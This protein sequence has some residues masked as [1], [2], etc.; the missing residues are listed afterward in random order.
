MQKQ[1][2]AKAKRL[3]V[4][5]VA[6]IINPATGELVGAQY[7]WNTGER[8]LEWFGEKHTD[9]RLRPLQLPCDRRFNCH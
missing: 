7:Q 3:F 1:S 8:K 4:R 5:A 2:G 9:Y 6:E